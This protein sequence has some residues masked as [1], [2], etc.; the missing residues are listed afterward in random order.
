MLPLWVAFRNSNIG[1]VQD[2]APNLA[3]QFLSEDHRNELSSLLWRAGGCGFLPPHVLHAV[4]LFIVRCECW[5]SAAVK[6]T[7]H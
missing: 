1:C 2:A 3:T 5:E 6:S 4:C 7:A